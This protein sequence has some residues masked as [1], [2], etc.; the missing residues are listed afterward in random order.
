VLAALLL[1]AANPIIVFAQPFL[2]DH[3]VAVGA[4]GAAQAPMRIAGIVGAVTAYR[5]AATLGLRQTLVMAPVLVAGSYALL[6]GWGS[7]YAFGATAVIFFVH[8]MIMPLAS[9]Y[10]NRRIPNNQRATILSLR[11]LATSLAIVVLQPGL[12]A[13]ADQVSLSAVFWVTAGFVAITA[14]PALYLWL[15]AD[16]R[17]GGADA[18]GARPIEARVAATE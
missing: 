5:I 17:E 12:G 14:P 15:R 8:S 11:Q 10:L 1:A 7:V 13:I 2:E 18:A 6:G 4:F 3:D 9:D 16:A